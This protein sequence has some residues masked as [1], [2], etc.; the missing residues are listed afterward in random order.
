VNYGTSTFYGLPRVSPRF[1]AVWRRNALVWRK[2]LGASLLGNLAD[3]LIYLLGLGYGLGALVGEVHGTPY[4]TFLAAGSLCSAT[5]NSA[6]FESFYSAFS[7]MHVQRTWDAIM[8]APVALEDVVAGELL[9]AASKASFSGFAILVVA[10]AL[11]LVASPIALWVI[12]VIPLVGLSF[13]APGLV[14]TACAQGYDFFTYYFTIFITPML[15]LSGVFFPLEQ[16]PRP[17]QWVAQCLP[18]SHA[19]ALVRPLMLGTAPPEAVLHIAVLVAY[20]V[21]GFY[22]AVV[23]LRRRL[24]A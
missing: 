24:L 5:M 22:L 21:L 18:L 7:R 12:A 6:T 17:L 1:G 2:L 4:I 20:A 9:W 3:P 14:V 23:L 15:F 10:A 13:A 11:G 16:L 8:N 19:T